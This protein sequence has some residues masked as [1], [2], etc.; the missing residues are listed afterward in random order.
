MK[1]HVEF[2]QNPS[3]KLNQPEVQP[4]NESDLI[5]E[6]EE[7]VNEKQTEAG[8]N[9]NADEND[10]EGKIKKF[11]ADLL[12]FDVFYVQTK[13]VQ[14]FGAVSKQKKWRKQRRRLNAL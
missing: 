3:E 5:E 14:V 11:K 7:D 9:Q 13:K 2:A 12:K 10:M 1:K 8:N 4:D 6:E